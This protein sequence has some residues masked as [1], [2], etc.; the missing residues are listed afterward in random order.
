MPI[1]PRTPNEARIPW[2]ELLELT[3]A[4]RTVSTRHNLSLG[5]NAEGIF[6]AE[7]LF[8]IE[9]VN[10]DGKKVPVRYVGEQH[11]REDLGRIPTAQDWLSQIKPARWMYGQRFTDAGCETCR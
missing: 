7:K 10:S 6:L 1:T 3:G 4:V 8:G 2:E 11:V 9:I 5:M